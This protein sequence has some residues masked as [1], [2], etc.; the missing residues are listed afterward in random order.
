MPGWL[1]AASRFLPTT[2]AAGAIRT[3]L[4][5]GREVYGE[6]LALALTAA[7]TLT[8]GLGLMKWRED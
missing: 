8:L 5:G 3:A 4:A 1:A 7:A 6:S 2:F